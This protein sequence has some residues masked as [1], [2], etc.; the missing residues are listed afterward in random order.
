MKMKNNRP[1]NFREREMANAIEAYTRHLSGAKLTREERSALE[2][3]TGEHEFEEMKRTVLLLHRAV[4]AESNGE[5]MPAE[6]DERM[7]VYLLEQFRRY[8]QAQRSAWGLAEAAA[9]MPAGADSELAQTSYPDAPPI[10]NPSAFA[11][12]GT[13]VDSPS[14]TARSERVSIQLE[15]FD[16]ME[17]H[18]MEIILHEA[19]F[20]RAF[21]SS[22]LI[23]GDPQVSR[24]HARVLLLDSSPV[25]TDIGSQ[26]GT[27]VNGVQVN[28]PTQ[29]DVGYIVG[30]GR[31]QLRVEQIESEMRGYARVVFSSEH[32]DRYCVDLS[33][34]VVGRSRT[35]ST[36]P[37]EDCSERMSRRHARFDLS[38]GQVYLTDLN[39]R[40]GSIVNGERIEGSIA[41][42]PEMVIQMGGAKLRVVGIARD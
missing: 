40:N 39:S 37:L 4:K 2:K 8:R 24:R 14:S 15:V 41:L 31:T 33:E 38:D 20:G 6:R 22:L 12:P 13:A 23:E 28:E 7:R 9:P 29:L 11:R 18:E 25:I 35:Q 34:A 5:G 1:Q 27:S 30:M 26:N 36:M 32:G 21:P 19:V 3:W 10:D 17:P 42:D 16:G